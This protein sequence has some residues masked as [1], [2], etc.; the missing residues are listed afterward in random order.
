MKNNTFKNYQRI[1]ETAISHNILT[2]EALKSSNLYDEYCLASAD[3]A[4][5]IVRCNPNATANISSFFGYEFDD[6]VQEL[7][8]RLINK[9]EPQIT[10]ILSKGPEVHCYNA[11]C[12]S[13]FLSYTHDL[14]KK[15]IIQEKTKTTDEN[16]KIHNTL[17]PVTKKDEFG[18]ETKV[19]YSF[20]LL[21]TPLS[22]D[23]IDSTE[24]GNTIPSEE[25]TPEEKLLLKEAIKESAE[26]IFSYLEH[27]GRRKSKGPLFALANL[28]LKLEGDK[29][30]QNII[31]RLSIACNENPAYFVR[32]YNKELKHLAD[33]L[34]I[35]QARV[36]PF[37]ATSLCDFGKN[38]NPGTSYDI[39]AHL[40]KFKY[41]SKVELAKLLSID[42]GP[43]QVRRKKNELVK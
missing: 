4:K 35:S 38:F 43:K 21:S 39:S 18:N 13:I 37:L 26:R 6:F 23:E 34:E 30:A 5:I 32:L 14:Y 1:M 15:A 3:I 8:T 16:G 31:H 19:T 20:I 29:R 24:L 22:S 9:F 2:N 33:T 7:T 42:L 41:K 36:K 12:T 17:T 10:A 27:L 11:Y 40:S 28:C 25:L